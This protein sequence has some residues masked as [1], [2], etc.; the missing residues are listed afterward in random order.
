MKHKLPAILLVT[1]ACLILLGLVRGEV[2][3]VLD[4]GTNLCLE[5]VGIG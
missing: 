3:T 2:T 1:A 4:K 5:C